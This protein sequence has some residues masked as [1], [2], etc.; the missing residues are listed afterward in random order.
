MTTPIAFHTVR[1]TL[2]RAVADAPL[3]FVRPDAGLL[4]RL[5]ACILDC[6]Y[7]DR[8]RQL[9]D[10]GATL[11]SGL[12]RLPLDQDGNLLGEHRIALDGR[13][14]HLQQ[15]DGGLQVSDY[16]NP[17]STQF[18]RGVSMATVVDR[19]LFG[20]LDMTGTRI[21]DCDDSFRF[22]EVDFS[23]FGLSLE[24]MQRIRRNNGDLRGA[25]LLP[26]EATR[27]LGGTEPVA[28]SCRRMISASIAQQLVWAHGN[29]ETVLQWLLDSERSL[30]HAS[31]DLDGFSLAGLHLDGVD[32]RDVQLDE[33][34]YDCNIRGAILHDAARQRVSAGPVSPTPPA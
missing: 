6:I 19:V 9:D 18:L 22:D 23:G 13:T 34:T 12:L 30:G 4:E 15:V 21:A 16:D 26:G 32:L 2:S 10:N 3:T 11:V 25:F 5:V 29:P 1:Q 20:W 17:S 28:Q 8:Q 14:I 7:G 33:A 24:D 27:L 31:I